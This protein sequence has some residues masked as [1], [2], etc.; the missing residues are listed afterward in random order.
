MR[1]I[2]R[3]L[4]KYEPLTAEEYR[5]LMEYI[6]DLLHNSMES[7]QIFYDRY[8]LILF[9][10]YSVYIP[11]FAHDIDDLI[12]YLLY[13]PGVFDKMNKSRD[14]SELFPEGLQNYLDFLLDK[15]TGY[16]RLKQL[17]GILE[18]S[19][20]NR[21]QMPS[22][23]TEKAVIK[24]EDANP[25][26]EIGLKSHFDRLIKYDFIT[27]I[28]TYRYL[29][30]NKASKDRIETLGAD[31]LGGIFT[32]KEKSIYYYIF[33]NEKDMSKTKNA[34]SILNMAFYGK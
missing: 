32:N 24:Y 17:R 10:D 22:A 12:N 20:V 1:Y 34:C 7:Y 9:Q 6:E 28:Q 18:T 31:R 29:T 3:K 25:Y 4:D 13:N 19:K 14:P 11:R 5:I 15:D 21:R 26:K 27:R 33:L 23:R 2:L 8:S 30:R 16:G